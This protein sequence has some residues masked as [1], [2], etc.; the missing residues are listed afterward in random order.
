MV[1]LSNTM[2]NAHRNNKRIFFIFLLISVILFQCEDGKDIANPVAEITSPQSGDD[3]FEFYPVIWNVED[4]SGVTLTELWIDGVPTHTDTIAPYILENPLFEEDILL[5]CTYIYNWNTMALENGQYKLSIFSE[6]INGNSGFTEPILVNIDNAL[7]IPD[8]VQIVSADRNDFNVIINW[9]TSSIDDFSKYLLQVSTDIE[10]SNIVFIDPSVSIIDTSVI[11]ENID[12]SS[13]IYF[14]V[15]VFDIYDFSSSSEVFVLPKDDSPIP[16]QILSVVYDT[17]EIEINWT[18]S[19][20][21]DFQ[22]YRI[23]KSSSPNNEGDILET[24]TDQNISE[25]SFTDFNPNQ[26][27]WFSIVVTDTL[28]LSSRSNYLA[29]DLNLPPVVAEIKSI[30][31]GLDTMDVRWSMSTEFDFSSY[32]VFISE[33]Q[34]SG[35]IPIDTLSNHFDTVYTTI[36]FDPTIENWFKIQTI[37]HWSLTSIG[38]SIPSEID[39]PPSASNMISV[40][41][42]L[43]S[44]TLTAQ[45]EECTD[46]DFLKYE[47][48]YSETQEDG[49]TLLATINEAD[50][51]IFYLS[52]F[53]P[54]IENW[55]KVRTHDQWGL[56][57]TGTELSASNN[58]PPTVSN[59]ISVEYGLDSMIVHWDLCPDEDFLKYEVLY[60]ET[61]ED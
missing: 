57:T 53:D 61:Q 39:S 20:N 3:L 40:I 59:I 2:L 11:I 21:P 41:Y 52:N 50:Q 47:V 30:S 44:L 33:S 15:S 23:F 12:P 56:T 36:N 25:Y 9:Q 1:S 48:L 38:Q 6:D 27:S 10:M 60:S 26:Q 46:E 51:N 49:Y 29:N 37:D 35:F 4:G 42:D 28:G 32:V 5:K 18:V 19:N 14:Q 58:Q 45:W 7:S 31:Y 22:D 16:I 24:I 55:F 17:L 8:P 34:Y 43:D 13:D 54:T